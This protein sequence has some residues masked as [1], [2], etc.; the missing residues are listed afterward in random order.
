MVGLKVRYFLG[1]RGGY[2]SAVTA[3][4][5]HGHGGGQELSKGV[6]MEPLCFFR[7]AL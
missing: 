7:D 5:Y 2:G 1:N 4:V 3:V 6:K